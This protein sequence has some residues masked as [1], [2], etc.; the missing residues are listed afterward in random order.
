MCP[1]FV[2]VTGNCVKEDGGIMVGKQSET[3]QSFRAKPSL[4]V[5][6]CVTLLHAVRLLG[7]T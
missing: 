4:V 5:N 2:E 6:C 7:L 1:L 3:L